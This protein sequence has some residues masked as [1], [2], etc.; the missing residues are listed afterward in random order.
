MWYDF[1]G[2]ILFVAMRVLS[3]NHSKLDRNYSDFE[4]A[5]NDND[6]NVRHYKEDINQLKLLP[7]CLVLN[8]NQFLLYI[9]AS[10]WVSLFKAK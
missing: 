1:L 3:Y 9:K 6:L 10:F 8:V 5:Q 7:F 4:I 2:A